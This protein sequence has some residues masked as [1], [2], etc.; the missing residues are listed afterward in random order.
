LGCS[1]RGLCDAV[2]QR[3]RGR[4]ELVL[5]ESG[6]GAVLTG[7]WLVGVSVVLPLTHSWACDGAL[8]SYQRLGQLH[9]TV[10]GGF[11]VVARATPPGELRS[12]RVASAVDTVD[13]ACFG[14]VSPWELVDTKGR[15]LVGMAQRRTQSG[16]VLVAGTLVNKVDWRLLCDAM[17]KLRDESTLRSR[18]VSAQE[19]VGFQIDPER[20]AFALAHAIES[21]L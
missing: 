18:T 4:T 13:W 21:A 3:L 11:G 20:Y 2:A 14:S 17:G 5:R 12:A 15:K 1:Q 7:P 10:L 9:A 8:T 16:V 19:M 6:G